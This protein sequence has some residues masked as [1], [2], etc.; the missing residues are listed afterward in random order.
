MYSGHV[1]HCVMSCDPVGGEEKEHT[2][3][4]KTVSERAHYCADYTRPDCQHCRESLQVSDFMCVH[5]LSSC[6]HTGL[7][8]KGF[9][10][11]GKCLNGGLAICRLPYYNAY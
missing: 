1:I 6:I 8:F 4:T 7:C 5:I 9:V 11:F 10:C 2:T 3:K